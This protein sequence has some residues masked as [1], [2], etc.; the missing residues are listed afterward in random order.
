MPYLQHTLAAGTVG[1]GTVPISMS[2]GVDNNVLPN[3]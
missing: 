3:S 2:T 1:A